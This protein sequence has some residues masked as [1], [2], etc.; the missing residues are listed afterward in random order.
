ADTASRRHILTCL[1]KT[2]AQEAPCANRILSTLLRRAWR[3]DV[4]SNEVK[5]FLATFRKSRAGGDD[6]PSAI[7]VALRNILVS[8]SFL[9][10]LEFDPAN[11]KA[12]QSYAANDFELA[13]RLSF[14]LWSS[15]PDDTLLKLASS[16]QLHNRAA[17]D[18]QVKRMLADK[19]S[20]ALID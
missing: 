2:A 1:P 16:K 19:K 4:S 3:R 13:S 14:F 18:G 20:D 17:F 5:P 10:R 12:G 9:F 6:F 15:S 7:A 11:A 8:P